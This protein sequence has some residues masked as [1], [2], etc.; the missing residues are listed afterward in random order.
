M[1]VDEPAARALDGR[2][3]NEFCDRLKE[4][5]A[6]ILE[7]APDDPFERAEGLRY[8]ARLTS[9]FLRATVDESDPAAAVLSSASPKIGLDN[10]DYVYTG[11]R[12]SPA[13]EYRLRIEPNDAQRL[14]IGLFSGALGTRQGLVRDAYVSSDALTPG[15]D[16]AFEIAIA[17][18]RRSGNWLP[19][20]AHT[21]ALQIRQTLLRRRSERPA[22]CELARV[23]AGAPPAPLDPA[24]FAAALDRAGQ[25]VGGVV[26][27]FLGWTASFAA[28]AHEIRPIDPA[29]LAVAQGDPNTSY[30]YGYWEIADGEAFV[31]DLHPPAHFDYWNL[32]I[33]NHWLESL[34]F[35]HRDTHVNHATARLRADGS[36]RIVVCANDPRIADAN[37]LDPAGHRRGALALRWVGA[38][39]VPAVPRTRVVNWSALRALD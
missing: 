29:L 9:H 33:G 35:L 15:S 11:A 24:A 1:R 7:A 37:W 20:G 10:P 36:V 34:D 3:W 5:G 6:R 31:V 4:T 18:E 26:A 19:L 28:H 8:L 12:L 30:H 39:A 27:Q 16:G 22:R 38:D 25:T 13:F 23:D 32:Q 21:N 2:V 14:G 17:R